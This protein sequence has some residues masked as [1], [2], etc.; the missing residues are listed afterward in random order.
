MKRIAIV[1]NNFVKN[2]YELAL[3]MQKLLKE[4][5]FEAETI[6]VEELK[7]QNFEFVF[8]IGG[9]GTLLKVAKFYSKFSLPVLGVNLGRLGFLAQTKENEIEEAISKILSNKINIEDRLMLQSNDFL[10]LNDFV[11]KG[12]TS[13]RTSKFNLSINDK[14]VCD[15]I[16]DGLIIATPTGSTA[17]G[18]SAGGPVLSPKLNAIVIVPICP[19]TLTAR[20]LVIP[21]DEKISISTCQDNTTFSVAADGE[22]LGFFT[23]TIDIQKSKTTAKLALLRNDDFYSILRNKLNWGVSPKN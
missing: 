9:D 21:Y 2:S 14:F 8:A 19:H 11:I 3:K 4:H 5:S 7:N 18:L 6:K 20:P 17:Y 23:A 12:A 16:A 22:D 13:S 15:Y 10:A 1:Y